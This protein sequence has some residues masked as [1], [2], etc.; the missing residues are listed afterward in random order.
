MFFE[1]IID[2]DNGVKSNLMSQQAHENV[3]HAT[4]I[5]GKC[6][7]RRAARA[8]QSPIGAWHLKVTAR[9][10]WAS[11]PRTHQNHT[12]HEGA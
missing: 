5:E 4:D 3:T 9:D 11:H 8:F 6:G 7:A 2:G 1:F 12:H 10:A